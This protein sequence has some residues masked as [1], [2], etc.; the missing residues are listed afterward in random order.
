MT[1]R[2][3]DAYSIAITRQKCSVDWIREFKYLSRVGLLMKKLAWAIQRYRLS[4]TTTVGR[5]V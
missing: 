3:I 1:H 2:A 5:A 4:P